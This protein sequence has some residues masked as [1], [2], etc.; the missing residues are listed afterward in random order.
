[1]EKLTNNFN[2]NLHYK[3]LI[4]LLMIMFTIIPLI[5][6]FDWDNTKS[7]N[8]D[9]K[10]VTITNALGLGSDIATIKLNTPLVYNVIDRGEGIYQKVAEFEIDNLDS[11]YSNT[12]KDMD[13]YDV[14][15]GMKK[16]D[17]AFKYKYKSITGTKIV[18]DYQTVCADEK[19]EQVCRNVVKG[20]HQEDVFEWVD[21]EESKLNKLPKGEIT[22][23]IFT[24]V[25]AGISFAANSPRC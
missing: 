1:M 10:E 23:A 2:I 11:D 25:E 20:T 21:L 22:I 24:D 12:L 4:V 8:P 19:G 17:R 6:A 7:Y 13:F 16:F 9:K 3:H 18:N 5:S 14:N 15:N